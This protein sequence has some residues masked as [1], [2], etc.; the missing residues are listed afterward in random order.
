MALY[1]VEIA[2]AKHALQ[3]KPF[4]LPSLAVRIKA[5]LYS[6]ASCFHFHFQ[7]LEVLSKAFSP[8]FDMKYYYYRIKVPYRLP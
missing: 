1:D 6:Y 2:L 7:Y 3:A 8:S 4:L 5:D